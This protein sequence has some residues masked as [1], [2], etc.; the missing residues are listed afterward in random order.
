MINVKSFA[1]ADDVLISLRVRSS[2]F[3]AVSLLPFISNERGPD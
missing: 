1:N 3:G 2:L